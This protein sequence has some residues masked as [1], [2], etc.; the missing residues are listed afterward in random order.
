MDYGFLQ[1][2]M[3]QSLID[4]SQKKVNGD[5]KLKIYKGNVTIVGR[6]SNSS[7]YSKEI[8]TFDE[9]NIYNQ[10]DAKGFIELNAS[11]KNIK[12]TKVNR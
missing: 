9:D 5:V 1:R 11:V 6:R 7:L 8:A 10:N 4:T 3:L 12:A 2:E